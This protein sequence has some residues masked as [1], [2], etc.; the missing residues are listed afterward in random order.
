MSF[1]RPLPWLSVTGALDE[2]HGTMTV[3]VPG[4][5]RACGDCLL[6]CKVLPVPD[7]EKPANKW[8][9]HAKIAHG[10]KIYANLPQSCRTWSC[11]WVLDAGLPPELQPHKSHVIFDM[12]TD[13]I[14][15]VGLGGEVDQHE[16]VQLWVDPIYPEAHRRPIVRE[17]IEHIAD[18]FRLSTLARIG[19][20]GILIAAPSLTS[21]R[22]WMEKISVLEDPSNPVRK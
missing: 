14:A 15:A 20:R 9:E 17:L 21:D 7:I 3:Q 18:K 8:C 11:L 19:G 6:C 22:K 13:Q 12:M 2:R 5:Q 4:P 10:C 16:V 1:Y